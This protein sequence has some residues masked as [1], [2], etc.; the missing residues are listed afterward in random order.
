[1]RPV[2]R[3]SLL[4]ALPAAR[5]APLLLVLLAAAWLAA[6]AAAA[7]RRVA[8]VIGNGEYQ[9]MS[10]LANPAHDARAVAALLQKKGFILVGGGVQLDLTKAQMEHAIAEL[11]AYLGDP[12]TV[13]LFYYAGH[14]VSV[15]ERNYL[16][17][18]DVAPEEEVDADTDLVDARTVVKAMASAGNKLNMVVLDACRS[19]AFASKTERIS[20]GGLSRMDVPGEMLISFSTQPGNVALDGSGE[21]SP[22]ATA[23]MNAI[24]KPGLDAIQVFNDVGVQVKA[25]TGGQQQPWISA[26]PIETSFTFTPAGAAAVP[27]L[28]IAVA[29]SP[30]ATGFKDCPDCPALVELP[31]GRFAMGSAGGS[32]DERPVHAVT[33]ARGFAM[34]QYEVTFAEWDAC[35][36]AGACSR[37]PDDRGWGHGRQPVVDVSWDDAGQYVRWLTQRTG[38]LYRLPTEAEWEYAA[39]AGA[40]GDDVKP[41]G[42]MDCLGCGS[43]WDNKQPAPVGSFK[44]NAFGLYDM[45]GNVWEWVA[46]CRTADYAAAPADGAAADAPGCTRRALRGGSWGDRI[47]LVRAANRGGTDPATR[48]GVIGFRVVREP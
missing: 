14:G 38:R 21:N 28:P 5:L 45:L 9:H 34:G 22:Y 24:G 4:A 18:V 29:P 7:E 17:P 20:K 36:A 3:P 27:Q 47:Q 44:P 41:V 33:L 30:G 42:I 8:L 2:R 11:G 48:S 1:M 39:R 31:P 43:R 35:V 6:P 37:R 16:V 10:V 19:V 23:L 32:A 12:D 13:G 15:R 26:S 46:D 40:A 25:A